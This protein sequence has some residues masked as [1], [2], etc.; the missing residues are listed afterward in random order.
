MA[1]KSIDQTPDEAAENENAEAVLSL[2]ET[3]GDE[4]EVQAHSEF[5]STT[6]ILASCTGA[7]SAS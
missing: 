1:D 6:S 2:Q 5:I 3:A 4:S 7:S